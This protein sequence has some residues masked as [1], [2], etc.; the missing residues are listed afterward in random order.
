MKESTVADKG[1]CSSI[2]ALDQLKTNFDSRGFSDTD[3]YPLSSS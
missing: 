1:R 3:L 2:W